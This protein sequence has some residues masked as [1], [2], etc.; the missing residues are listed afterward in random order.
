MKKLFVVA[1]ILCVGA[2]YAEDFEPITDLVGKWKF[3]RYKFVSGSLTYGSPAPS[4]TYE[5]FDSQTGIFYADQNGQRPVLWMWFR[6]DAF[7][8]VSMYVDGEEV[9]EFK[10]TFDIAPIDEHKFLF[11]ERWEDP[12]ILV[13][14][15]TRIKSDE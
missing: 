14:I 8:V 7:A 6:E 11:V 10:S 2:V 3:E 15:M 13:G 12:Y 9:H 5:F 4:F 1:L